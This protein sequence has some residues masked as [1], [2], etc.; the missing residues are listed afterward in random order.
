[1]N[2]L[3]REEYKFLK[4]IDACYL[5]LGGSM[6]YGTN[7]ENSD[8]DIRGC[9]MEDPHSFFF[10]SKGKKEEI[11]DAETDTVVYTLNKYAKLLCACNP[12]VIESL[13]VRDEDVLYINEVGKK[14][15]D[16]RELFLS[17][18]AYVTFAQ[19]AEAQ[20]R[21]L[22]NALARDSYPQA[23]KENHIMRSIE[24]Q[25]LNAKN[26]YQNFDK[27]NK[28]EFETRDSS[29]KDY[30]KEIY[31]SI[32]VKDMPLRDFLRVNSDMSN[33]IRNYGKLNKRNHKKD[34]NHL[35]K[36]AMHLIRLYFMGI[37]II[38]N[39]EIVTYR[40]K[41]HDL[42]MSIRRGEV[43]FE[44]IFELQKKLK[45]ELDAAYA[46]TTLPDEPQ[47]GKINKMLEEI[48]ISKL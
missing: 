29:K 26:E 30:D 17:K 15:R 2:I 46:E 41:E 34:F 47:I 40:E 1:M 36:H 19:Y 7:N 38:K 20:L 37:D 31:I 32:D 43:E 45:K 13:G 12:N 25:M 10:M 39:H 23:E 44:K 27:I 6:A 28:I 5:V 24:A 22:E 14:L 11:E 16:N 4:G 42:L 18:K 8:I 9:Y 21:R 3:E 48:Y 33:M 35:C